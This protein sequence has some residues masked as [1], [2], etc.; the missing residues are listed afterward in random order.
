ME[1]NK[2][3]VFLDYIRV[4][5]CFMVIVVHV[6]ECYYCTADGAVLANDFDRF[7]VSAIDSLFRPA[8]PLFVMVS[9]Y[10]LLPL[11]Y[12]TSVF[13][14][15]RFVRVFIPFVIWIVLYAIVPPAMLFGEGEKSIVWENFT[16]ILYNFTDDAGH[17]WFVYM[18]I[19]VYCLMP[20][21]SPWLKEVSKRGEQ[22]FLAIWF[23]TTFHHYAKAYLGGIWGECVW[24]EFHALYYFS[25]YIGYVVLA[26]YIRTH[27][28]WSLKKSLAI[29]IPCILVGYAITAGWFYTY[30]Q[31]TSDYYM[32]EVSWRFCT[33]NVALMSFGMFVIM[34]HFTCDKPAVYNPVKKVSSLSYGIYLMH[35]FVLT[36][37]FGL[38]GDKFTTPV[39]ILVV[40]LATYFSCILITYLIS[41]LPGSKYLIG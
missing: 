13:V 5:A 7:W 22:I 37:M 31:A 28:N 27:I 34:K 19:G 11:P 18:L 39:S 8:V 33:F 20:I 40:A 23:L 24:N 1:Q 41:K 15:K 3:I 26:H 36:F 35:I 6:C 14:K 29:G 10:L 9:S 2:R 16:H 12:S 4:I 38:I 30:T 32:V 17:L 21:I 25:G